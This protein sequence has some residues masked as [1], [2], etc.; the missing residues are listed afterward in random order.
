M[1]HFGH[2]PA[3]VAVIS[4]CIGQTNAVGGSVSAGAGMSFMP[5]FGHF[6]A[7]EATIS[8][9][10]RAGVD[11]GLDSLTAD[12]VHLGDEGERLVGRSLEV[13]GRSVPLR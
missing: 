4:G 6:P 13:A 8:A 12:L 7:H 10:H 2:V 11:A 3:Q 1:P 5:H 9:M